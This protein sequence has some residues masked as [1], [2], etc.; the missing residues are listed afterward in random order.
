VKTV[1]FA[2]E[3]FLAEGGIARILRAYAHALSLDEPGGPPV[4]VIVLNDSPASAGRMPGYLRRERLSPLYLAN[5]SKVRF[6]AACLRH[7]ASADRIVC[8]HI[9]L[10]GVARLVQRIRPSLRYYIVAHGIDVWRPYTRAERRHLSQAHRVLC[11]SEYTRRQILRFMPSLDPQR[12]AIVPNT[13]DPDFVMPEA[14]WG[15][16][17]GPGPRILTVARLTRDDTYK[18]VDTLIEAMPQVRAR[19]PGARLIVVGGG[20]DEGRIRQLARENGG[21]GAVDVLG[22]V[23]DAALRAEYARCTLFALPSRKEGFGL[24]F[25]EAMSFG[26]P[27]LGARAGG[28][29]EVVTEDVGELVEYGHVD[30]IAD[31][32]VRLALRRFDP[33]K[34]RAHLNAFSFDVFRQRLKAALSE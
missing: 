11:V 16:D 25:L 17:A 29:P 27:C 19:L 18:G 5:R 26:K 9:H 22:R 7:G 14:P 32:C 15:P 34:I 13:L 8:G 12:L 1:L 10:A 21:P 23:D 28:I 4:G 2:P 3:L 31:A 24:V 33:L 6:I 20:N 30:H